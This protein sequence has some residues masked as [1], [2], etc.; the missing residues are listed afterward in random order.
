MT[1]AAS[2]LALA[3]RGRQVLPGVIAS[4]IV[5]SAASFL[6]EHYSAPVMLLALLLG[7]SMNFLSKQGSASAG[8]EFAAREIL[9][10]GVALLGLRITLDQ[11]AGLGW[12]VV[13]LVVVSMAATILVS[14]AAA[15]TL[16][17]NVLFGFLT[18]GATAICG[19]SAALALAASLPA[20]PAKERATSFTVVGVSALST[21]AMVFY[22][23][24]AQWLGLSPH[25]TGVFL[26]ATIYDVAQV[27]GAGYS[28]SREV[29]DTA[30]VV[31]LMRVALL[32]PVIVCATSIARARGDVT[33]GVRAPL[34]PWF[35][36]VFI[37]LAVVNSTGLVVA[38][39]RQL[40]SELSRWC[41][42]VAISAIGMKTRLQE[43]ATVGLRPIVLMVGE[44]L[45]LAALVLALWRVLA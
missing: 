32:V 31:K 27:V 13:V 22:P 38:D 36:V 30:T 39:I 7:M 21:L 42:I 28:V 12:Q 25:A 15:R 35:A 3:E 5:A 6:A 29:G 44:T 19:V 23:M 41:L 9:R 40:G 20:H 14:M 45:F 26:G 18:G 1:G 43:L 17:F 4:A 34:L 11:I 2:P 37:L 33:G 8:I 16:R 24:L 10:I